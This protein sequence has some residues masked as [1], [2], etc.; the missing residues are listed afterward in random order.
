MTSSVREAREAL[1]RRLREL[2]TDAGLS[3][4]GLA[5]LSGWHGS[6]VSKIEYGRQAPSE[7]DIRAWCRHTGSSRELADLVA[8][9]RSIDAMYLEWRRT[10][11]TGTRRRQRD[12]P[13]RDGVV[14]LLRLY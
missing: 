10:L 4:R 9:L 13:N 5:E 12:S 3:G 11:G 2:R 8:S 1:G 14:R 7:D 6:K